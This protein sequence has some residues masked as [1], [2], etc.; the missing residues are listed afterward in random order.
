MC[1]DCAWVLFKKNFLGEERCNIIPCK[2]VQTKKMDE[3]HKNK[4]IKVYKMGIKTM[5]NVVG[6]N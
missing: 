3:R 4:I 1:Y 5:L 6:K 2:Y